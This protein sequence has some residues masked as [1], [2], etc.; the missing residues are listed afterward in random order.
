MQLYS[1][2]YFRERLLVSEN[3]MFS[4]EV[5]ALKERADQFLSNLT[6]AESLFTGLADRLN[7][8][9]FEYSDLQMGV[10]VLQVIVEQ[11]LRQ[12]LEEARAL[13]QDLQNQVREKN[14]QCTIYFSRQDAC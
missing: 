8:T 10:S 6:L 4:M 3:A 12:L 11:E 7:R 1:F 14:I 13:Y 5:S 2:V 9:E